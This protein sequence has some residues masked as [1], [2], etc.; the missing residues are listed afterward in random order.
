MTFP[1]IEAPAGSD[2]YKQAVAEHLQAAVAEPELVAAAGRRFAA[3]PPKPA[4]A[5]IIRELPNGRWRDRGRA[6]LVYAGERDGIHYWAPVTVF[7]IE[8][9]DR[10][11]IAYLPEDTV[12]QGIGLA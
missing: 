4:G 12:I 6:R 3:R 9:E 8:P 11:D 5:R 10:L 1:D 7:W 2:W